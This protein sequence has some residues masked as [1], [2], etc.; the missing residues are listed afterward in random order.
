MENE[1]IIWC[2]TCKHRRKDEKYCDENCNEAWH[3][4]ESEDDEEETEEE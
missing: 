3:G 4:Y 2:Y 1:G